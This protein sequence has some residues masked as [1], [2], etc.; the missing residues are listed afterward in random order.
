M[1]KYVLGHS[2]IGVLANYTGGNWK[3]GLGLELFNR[4]LLTA[5]SKTVDL[6]EL[7][8]DVTLNS[9]QDIEVLGICNHN[10]STLGTY[11]W[12]CFSDSGRTIS[13]YDSGPITPYAY[14]ESIPHKTTCDTLDAP[15]TN[16]Y[17]RLTINDTNADGYI[18]IGR[19]FIGKRFHS[20]CNMD[21]GLKHGVDT[22]KTIVETSTAGVEA[23]VQSIRSRSALFTHSLGL[24]AQGNEFYDMQYG[25]GISENFL[26]EFDPDEKNKGLHT[27][28]ARNE[29]ISPLDYPNSNINSMAFSLKE[30]L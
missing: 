26:Y 2:D 6:S 16:V 1:A 27:F 7:I 28:M 13:V 3:V 23:F 17:W 5:T 20:T 8:L 14:H 30:V 25:S 4:T 9:S 21:Y 11:Q 10:I 24:R 29:S 19:L 22:G 18:K 12:E 15:I